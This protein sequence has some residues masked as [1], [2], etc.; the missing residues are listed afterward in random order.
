ME[1][2]VALDVAIGLAFVYLLLSLICTAMNEWIAT[3]FRLRAQTLKRF[4]DRRFMNRYR[5]PPAT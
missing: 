4:I 3:I 1:T 5:V 2:F